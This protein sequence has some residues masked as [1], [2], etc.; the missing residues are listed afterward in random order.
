MTR[1]QGAFTTRLNGQKRRRTS[2]NTNRTDVDNADDQGNDK[3][4]H[5]KQNT[6]LQFLLFMRNPLSWVVK[7]VAIVAIAL[8]NSRGRPPD[9]QDFVG[10]VSLLLVNSAIGFYEERGAGNAIK[11]LMDSS[12]SK[13][14]NPNYY[15]QLRCSPRDPQ[16]FIPEPAPDPT[17]SRLDSADYDSYLVP[18]PNSASSSLASVLSNTTTT[19][20]ANTY[21]GGNT[22]TAATDN[23]SAWFF[24][25]TNLF[26]LF[27]NDAMFAFSLPMDSAADQA[28]TFYYPLQSANSLNPPW[29]NWSSD[30][31]LST[32]CSPS[33]SSRPAVAHGVGVRLRSRRE[34]QQR[35]RSRPRGKIRVPPRWGTSRNPP[36]SSRTRTSTRI[37]S[38]TGTRDGRTNRGSSSSPRAGS[39]CRRE[40]SRYGTLCLLGSIAVGCR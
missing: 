2:D 9:W 26:L 27:S 19:T 4:E 37:T 16:H 20:S 34:Q 14:S 15:I 32:V 5:K 21:G 38:S 25:E 30:L 23:A 18:P 24:T 17:H 7:T 3:L 33:P 13:S 10:I 11:A 22:T 8:S 29:H 28:N 40:A 1:L 31:N 35:R 6:F 39:S 36:S 12:N